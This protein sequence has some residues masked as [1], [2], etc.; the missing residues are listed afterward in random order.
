MR[1][2][3][4]GSIG[5][6]MRSGVVLISHDYIAGRHQIHEF[7]LGRKKLV[8]VHIQ[9]DTWNLKTHYCRSLAYVTERCR[10]WQ[11]KRLKKKAASQYPLLIGWQRNNSYKACSRH[12]LAFFP[13][14]SADS[15]NNLA[16]CDAVVITH[17]E[18]CIF[19][20]ATKRNQ[21]NRHWRVFPNANRVQGSRPS[22]FPLI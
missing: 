11:I 18:L 14:D 16:A 3:Q 9:D 7:C 5:N 13:L 1:I 8:K 20:I 10:C 17:W 22:H 6:H 4:S 21:R 2:T 19:F 12:F 15:A